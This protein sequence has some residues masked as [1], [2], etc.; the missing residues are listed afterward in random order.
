VT[1]VGSTG[2]Q[3][4]WSA[5]ARKGT[6]ITLTTA[7]GTGPGL[8]RWTRNSAQLLAGTFVDTIVVTAIGATGSP[9]FIV[10]SLVVQPVLSVSGV[11]R[12]TLT[13][14]SAAIKS[15]IANLVIVGDPG[16]TIS[17]TASHGGA[18]WLSLTTQSGSGA[19]AIQW[20]K[21]ASN[22][23][24]GIFIDTITV[25]APG[26]TPIRIVDTLTVIA[27][28]TTRTCVVNHLLGAPCLDA[29]QLKWLDL[30]GNRDGA[31]NLGDLLS[32][33]ARPPAGPATQLRRREP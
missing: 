26:T 9:A 21:T 22:L 17:W 8:V 7:S 14:G 31:F 19:A 2:A 13:S 11:K 24:D 10:D 28:P 3:T 6:W 5:T 32:Y 29:T 1:F 16:N 30:A 18:A 20:T 23:R 27:P 25:S 12:D 15:T 4:Q 33:L